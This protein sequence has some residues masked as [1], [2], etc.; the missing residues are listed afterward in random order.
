MADLTVL[1]TEPVSGFTL[2]MD[3]AQLKNATVLVCLARFHKGRA[4]VFVE[5]VG[6]EYWEDPR[7]HDSEFRAYHMLHFR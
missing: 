1:R 7:L 2:L 6:A 4:P 3:P 5:L